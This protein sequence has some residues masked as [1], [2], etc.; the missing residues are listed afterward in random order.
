[1]NV[2]AETWQAVGEGGPESGT[3]VADVRKAVAELPARE[4]KVVLL[5]YVLGLSVRETGEVLGVSRAR[6]HQ[7]EGRALR[8]LRAVLA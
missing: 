1:M 2:S 3:R 4:R 7:L 8:M 6:A 5:R